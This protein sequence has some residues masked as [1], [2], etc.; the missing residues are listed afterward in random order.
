MKEITGRRR[1]G[2][3][4]KDIVARVYPRAL[5][6]V[7]KDIIED[8]GDIFTRSLH[9]DWKVASTMSLFT[10]GSGNT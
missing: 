7:E 2:F 4:G 5:Q 9:S 8:G 6:K 10:T 1:M 3:L